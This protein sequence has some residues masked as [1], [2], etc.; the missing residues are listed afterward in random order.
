MPCYAFQ[1]LRP[2]V[3]PASFVHPL[4]SLIGDVIV[5]PGCYIAPF[6][7][8]RGDFGRI[9]VEGDSSIQDCAVI[10]TTSVNDALVRRGA[11]V[12][13]GAVLH[14]CTVG[15]NALIGMNA[16][17]LDA[18]VIGDECLVAAGALVRFDAVFEARSMIA[19][20]P[21]K[22]IRT[23]AMDEVTWKSTPDSAY[24]VLARESLESLEETTPLAAPEPDRP[25]VRGDT[26]AV[27][28]SGEV[29]AAR[30]ER[31]KDE[32]RN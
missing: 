10:H 3:D 27:R 15:A 23:F 21:A 13:H 32:G 6:A 31:M 14:G 8:L 9:V 19:G 30:R 26:L 20:S 4:A 18:A 17:V 2:V 24:R 28:L 25:R 16:V 7:S 1:G 29:G 11:T 22:L 5:G 12:A